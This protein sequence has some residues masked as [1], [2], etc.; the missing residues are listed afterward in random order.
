MKRSLKKTVLGIG[1]ML[2]LIALPAYST[3]VTSFTLDVPGTGSGSSFSSTSGSA[4]INA[5]TYGSSTL[6][7][8]SGE[9]LV[10]GFGNAS[11]PSL[12]LTNTSGTSF[13]SGVAS[14]QSLL[15]ATTGLSITGT[16]TSTSLNISFTDS[17]SYVLPAAFFND[18]V[19]AGVLGAGTADAFTLSGGLIGSVGSVTSSTLELSQ[20]SQTPEPSS[21]FLFG[22]G[23]SIVAAMAARR[24][25]KAGRVKAA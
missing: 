18:L 9:D 15:S 20:V 3:P 24:R 2:T 4:L 25:F 6:N 1:G 13:F 23:L 11:S 14:G 19:T 17:T 8:T 12:T 10:L 22:A 7:I 21:L 5:I 16:Q